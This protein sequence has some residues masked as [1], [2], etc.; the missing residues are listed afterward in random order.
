MYNQQFN[1]QFQSRNQNWQKTYQPAGQVPSY[2]NQNQQQS[3]NQV[4]SQ[5]AF[6]SSQY[7]GNQIGHDIAGRSDSFSPTQQAGY[8]SSWGGAAPIAQNPAQSFH[9]MNYQGNQLGHDAAGRSDSFSPTQHSTQFGGQFGA[10]SSN[11]AG[12][13][14]SPYQYQNTNNTGI[15]SGWG[16]GASGQ[17][18][19]TSNYHGN[20]LGH[21]AALRG[22]SFTS[23]QQGYGRGM[24]SFANNQT[25]QQFGFNNAY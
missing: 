14:Q 5:Q 8:S 3:F 19:H 16:A 6:H 2:Y 4:P 7:R 13:G 25:N 21:D 12:F 24:N 15:Q 18:F 23:S 11:Q 22:D 17:S 20:Q 9:T 10:A 1:P